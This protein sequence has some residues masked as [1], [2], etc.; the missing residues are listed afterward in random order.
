MP[1]VEEK[2]ELLELIVKD[3]KI[4][5]EKIELCINKY[6]YDEDGYSFVNPEFNKYNDILLRL[7]YRGQD[8][9]I[10]ELGFSSLTRNALMRHGLRTIHDLNKYNEVTLRR[11]RNIGSKCIK[12]IKVVLE[13]KGYILA[14]Y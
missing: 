4:C 9:L 14:K 10:E 2:L 1:T 3:L 13:S 6:A 11:I 7:K 5:D 8:I 12:E